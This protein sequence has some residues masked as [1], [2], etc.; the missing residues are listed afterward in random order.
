MGHNNKPVLTSAHFDHR[1]YST[2]VVFLL[3][4]APGNLGLSQLMAMLTLAEWVTEI[5]VAVQQQLK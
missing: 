4:V 2:E 3:G 1:E 5:T